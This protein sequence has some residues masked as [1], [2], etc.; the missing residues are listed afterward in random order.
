M[1]DVQ[2]SVQVTIDRDVASVHRTGGVETLDQA[3]PRVGAHRVAVAARAGRHELGLG[4]RGGRR[5]RE[6]KG[7]TGE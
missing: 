6:L 5:R 4:G 2:C 7:E 1:Q 3:I